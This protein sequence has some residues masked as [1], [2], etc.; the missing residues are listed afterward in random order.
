MV[1]EVNR[2]L[3]DLLN[4]LTDN[5]SLLGMLVSFAYVIGPSW[6]VFLE[7]RGKL[8]RLGVWLYA[9]VVMPIMVMGLWAILHPDTY[10]NDPLQH[11]DFRMFYPLWLPLLPLLV[12][13]HRSPTVQHPFLYGIMLL[14]FGLL[15][16]A[17][18]LGYEVLHLTYQNIEGSGIVFSG[19]RA[20]ECAVKDADA[21]VTASRAMG[22]SVAGFGLLLLT[23]MAVGRRRA[24]MRVEDDN[25]DNGEN[26]NNRGNPNGSSDADDGDGGR[27]SRPSRL[28]RWSR[29]RQRGNVGDDASEVDEPKRKKPM[30]KM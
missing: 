10:C 28:S 26:G 12:H 7:K 15:V 18:T 24:G 6:M 25:G 16:F 20:W 19:A 22:G 17:L 13:Q 11:S 21:Y 2:V 14:V 9:L 1:G 8:S 5:L 27:Q 3:G 30:P 23:T 29:R 4:F